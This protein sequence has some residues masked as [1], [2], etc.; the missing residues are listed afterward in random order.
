MISGTVTAGGTPIIQMTLGGQSWDTIV[1]TGFNGYLEL[2]EALH[3]ALN[4][5]YL[6]DSVSV[7]AAGQTIVEQ[8]FEITFD[9]MPVTAEVTFVPGSQVLLGTALLKAHRLDINFKAGTVLI[10]RIP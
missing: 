7:L 6:F 3:S 1:D 2:P 8:L 10:E 4:P 5:Q 9:G